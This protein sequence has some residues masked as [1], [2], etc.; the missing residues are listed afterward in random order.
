MM[1]IFAVVAAFWLLIS[2]ASADDLKNVSSAEM[3]NIAE[4]TISGFGAKVDIARKV[5]LNKK[6]L[7]Y[8]REARQNDLDK[9][10]YFS[11]R[12]IKQSATELKVIESLTI[13]SQ[14]SLS[15]AT[16]K[17]RAT[18]MMKKAGEWSGKWSVQE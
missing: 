11:A 5:M 2:P 14:A 4:E 3:R 6:N 17:Y 10:V 7:K 12:P 9:G 16:E 8:S 13:S 1:K 15:G 18:Y